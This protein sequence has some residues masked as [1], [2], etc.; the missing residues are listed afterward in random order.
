MCQATENPRTVR[1]RLKLNQTEFWRRVGVTQSAGSRY[2]SGRPLPK[3]LATLLTI[4]Y[5]TDKQSRTAVGQ[6]R[7]GS[8]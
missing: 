1:A 4:A 7:G 5:G 8:Q 6:L 3:P 2:E